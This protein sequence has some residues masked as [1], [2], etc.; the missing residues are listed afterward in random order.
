MHY[1][2]STLFLGIYCRIHFSRH[3]VA[4]FVN[5]DERDF[6]KLT[7]NSSNQPFPIQS[8]SIRV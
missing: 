2:F 7:I 6:Y 1:D 8:A 3:I 5:A 4:N